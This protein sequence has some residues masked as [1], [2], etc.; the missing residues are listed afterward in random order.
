MK[1]QINLTISDINDYENTM[2]RVFDL[3]EIILIHYA[4]E[5]PLNCARVLQE[6]KDYADI[7]LGKTEL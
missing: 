1:K 5:Q 4:K 7:M 3:L 6:L 2:N